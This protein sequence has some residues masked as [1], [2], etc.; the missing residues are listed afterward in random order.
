SYDATVRLWE[1]ISGNPRR[2]LREYADIAV[3]DVAFAPDGQGLTTASGNAVQLWRSSSGCLEH[4]LNEHAGVVRAI[5]FAPDGVTLA[6]AFDDVVLL[7]NVTLGKVK[8]VLKEH[9]GT[10]TS[11]AFAPDGQNLA[12]GSGDRVYLWNPSRGNLRSSHAGHA[13]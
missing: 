5:A 11:I 6:S 9:R 4:S 8:R 10:V 7:W 2:V 13:A 12:S 3:R 1:A